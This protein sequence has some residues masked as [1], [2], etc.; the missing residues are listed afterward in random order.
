MNISRLLRFLTSGNLYVLLYIEDMEGV[1]I[2]P[3]GPKNAYNGEYND[4]SR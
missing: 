1:V 3:T 4:N 2:W